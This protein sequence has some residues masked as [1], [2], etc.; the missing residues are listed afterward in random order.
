MTTPE[1]KQEIEHHKWLR[2]DKKRI[3]N[4]VAFAWI[5][6]HLPDLNMKFDYEKH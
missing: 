3:V 1:I 4:A 6:W 5:S 2:K